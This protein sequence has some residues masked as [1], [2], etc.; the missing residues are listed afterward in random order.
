[1]WQRVASPSGRERA[2][3]GCATA[4]IWGRV[5]SAGFCLSFTPR[6][7]TEVSKSR[8]LNAPSQTGWHSSYDFPF[9]RQEK[10][11]MLASSWQLSLTS[12]QQAGRNEFEIDFSF[13]VS[14]GDDLVSSVIFSSFHC[15]TTCEIMKCLDGLSN[16][17]ICR[18]G[19][20]SI[21]VDGPI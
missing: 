13:P 14:C 5:L 1:M 12:D 4:Q 11:Q 16:Q 2:W 15:L 10:L 18:C 17:L 20:T 8:Y 21:V 9:Q 7:S 6:S 19:S 3:E